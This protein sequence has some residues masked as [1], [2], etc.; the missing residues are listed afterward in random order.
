MLLA[1][2][3]VGVTT[4]RRVAVA[5]LFGVG[6]ISAYSQSSATIKLDHG[7]VTAGDTLSMELTFDQAAT[8]AQPVL[9]G[10]RGTANPNQFYLA[11]QGSL[12][13]GKDTATLTATVP[14]D[15][16]GEFHTESQQSYLRP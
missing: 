14:R 4:L 10:M 1:A 6:L 15:Y 13:A 11:F 2:Y 8:C 12:D 9:V 5:A 16:E 7:E 3:M